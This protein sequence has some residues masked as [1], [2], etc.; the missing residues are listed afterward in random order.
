[1]FS[2]PRKPFPFQFS[3]YT[4]KVYR[5]KRDTSINILLSPT[6]LIYEQKVLVHL[7]TQLGYVFA[8]VH[9]LIIFPFLVSY[10]KTGKK[11]TKEFVQGSFFCLSS[12]MQLKPYDKFNL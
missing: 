11:T 1:M 4:K 8:H 12:V 7:R 3:I 6:F 2:R 10:F 5:V 9:T